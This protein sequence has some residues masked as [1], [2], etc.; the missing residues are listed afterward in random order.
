MT[1]DCVEYRFCPDCGDERLFE[2]FHAED[3]PDHPEPGCPE[4]GCVDC[5][6]A[7]IIGLVVPGYISGDNVSQA[8]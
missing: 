5:G 4:V 1:Q 8:A 2:R 6:T 3:C 7:L